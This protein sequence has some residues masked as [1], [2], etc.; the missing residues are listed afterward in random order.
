MKMLLFVTVLGLGA[1]K[2]NGLN[3]PA[4]LSP[5]P[6]GMVRLT[7]SATSTVSGI[8][9]LAVTVEA[10]GAKT[11]IQLFA[12]AAIP[13]SVTFDLKVVAGYSATVTVDAVDKTG[14]I[15][16]TGS[17][18]TQS[19]TDHSVDLLITLVQPA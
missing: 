11:T 9:H 18:Q 10:G 17:G 6:S 3:G 14:R 19:A 2:S 1:C 7:V 8:D 5:P 15:L 16:A 13:P 12:P 4:D